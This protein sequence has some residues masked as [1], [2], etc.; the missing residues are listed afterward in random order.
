MVR[1]QTESDFCFLFLFLLVFIFILVPKLNL[2]LLSYIRNISLYLL[3]I[4]LVH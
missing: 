4:E 1:F 2:K 3:S